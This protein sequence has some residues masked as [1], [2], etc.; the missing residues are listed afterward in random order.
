MEILHWVV[1]FLTLVFVCTLCGVCVGAFVVLCGVR[2]NLD[3]KKRLL[4]VEYAS[5]VSVAIRYHRELLSSRAEEAERE[6]K[7][8]LRYDEKVAKEKLIQAVS[9]V[10]E[11]SISRFRTELTGDD[12]DSLD[13][14]VKEKQIKFSKSGR[15]VTVRV[16]ALP[17]G[18]VAMEWMLNPTLPRPLTVICQR[19]CK[20]VDK[21]Y[22][23][24]GEC[25]ADL[26]LGQEYDFTFEAWDG[27]SNQE[28][29]LQFVMR[30]PTAQE[31]NRT[32]TPAPTQAIDEEAERKGKILRAIRKVT[33]EA[34][35][36]EAGMK[37]AEQ[38]IDASDGSDEEKRKRKASIRA[39]IILARNQQEQ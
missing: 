12:H 14:C 3:A 16:A 15:V 37:E 13:A 35:A 39:N 23:Y 19:D 4:K 27:A 26:Q 1:D 38:R 6:R 20:V 36:W 17:T 21:Q 25:T 10:R 29:S 5:E 18:R 11:E 28:D 7:A 30:V 24:R 33:G 8:N 31:W 9:R 32:I 2:Q 34:E 22:S